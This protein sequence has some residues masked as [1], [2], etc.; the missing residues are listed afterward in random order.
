MPESSDDPPGALPAEQLPPPAARAP[1]GAQAENAFL[2]RLLEALPYPVSYI[3]ADLVYRQCNAAAAATVGRTPG[4]IVGKPVASIVGAD[5]EVVTLLRRVLDSGEPYEGTLEFTPP[6]SAR[7]THYR[8]SYVPDTD[9]DGRTLG[10]LTNVVDV[11]DL[12]ENEERFVTLALNERSPLPPRVHEAVYRITQ[13]AL[14]N[15][16]RHAKAES[17]WVQIDADPS[18]ARLLVGDDGCGFDPGASVDSSHI[19]LRSMRERAEGSGGLLFLRSAAG[20]GTTVKVD[21]SLDD[22]PR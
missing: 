10:V 12:R 19:G 2:K 16:V 8:V 17:A 3:D 11:T 4:E 9:G 15:V 1:A 20:E 21:W 13:E 14:N 22:G 7:T 6:G 18:Q 5:S